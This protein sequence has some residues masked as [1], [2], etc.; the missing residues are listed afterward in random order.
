VLTALHEDEE[1]KFHWLADIKNLRENLKSLVEGNESAIELK[2]RTPYT[3]ETLFI[4]GGESQ[5]L[6]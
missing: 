6:K 4:A 2:G 3:G 1:G 5:D